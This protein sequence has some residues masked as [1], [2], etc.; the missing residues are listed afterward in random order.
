[1]LRNPKGQTLLSIA[2]QYGHENIVEYLC[3]HHKHC[4][5]DD[6]SLDPGCHSWEYRAFKA[7]V[8]SRDNKG[9]NV[10]N[11]ATFHEKTKILRRLLDNGADPTVRNTYGKT[12]IDSAKDDLDAA[13]AVVKD[14][15][16]IRAVLEE[17]D[18]NQGSK[19][20]GTGKAGLLKEDGQIEKKLVAP[21]G[22]AVEMQLEMEKDEEAKE[23]SKKT[24]KG[25]AKK[26]GTAK[27]KLQK[28]V[29]KLSTVNKAKKK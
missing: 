29:K 6:F 15:S 14:R 11:I 19:I 21:D 18:A 28:G 20:F 12:A 27:G 23:K 10:A 3:E 5:D 4:D 25:G 17:W 22:T 16:E 1:M 24:A 2:A 26:K 13:M 7:N 8:N 9:W